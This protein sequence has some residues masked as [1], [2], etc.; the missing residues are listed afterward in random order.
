MSRFERIKQQ[1]KKSGNRVFFEKAFAF[2]RKIRI[3]MIYIVTY[4]KKV[5][6]LLWT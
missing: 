1:S 6:V 5:I 4:I 3:A 2:K